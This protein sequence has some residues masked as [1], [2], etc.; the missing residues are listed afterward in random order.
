MA[1]K[2]GMLVVILSDD[3]TE[4]PDQKRFLGFAQTQKRFIDNRF[5]NRSRQPIFAN[6]VEPSLRIRLKEKMR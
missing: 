5:S 6:L 1:L 2:K 4:F 3:K